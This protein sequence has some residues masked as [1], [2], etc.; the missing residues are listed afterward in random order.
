[1]KI[2]SLFRRAATS[3]EEVAKGEEPASTPAA[4]SEGDPDRETS[5]NEQVEGAAG[6]PWSDD[7]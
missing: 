4:F 6:Q 1:M 5:T 2:K 3:V 7:T